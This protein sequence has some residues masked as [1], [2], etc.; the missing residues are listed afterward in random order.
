MLVVIIT[1]G[2]IM[3]FL[4]GI[5]ACETYAISYPRDRFSKWWRK[6]IIQNI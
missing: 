3:M 2:M 5:V 4:L 1:I 6:H